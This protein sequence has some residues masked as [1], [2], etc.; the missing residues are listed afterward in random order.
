MIR[1]AALL[2]CLPV[3]AGAQDYPARPVRVLSTF[4]AGS[5]ADALMR[6][7]GAKMG[8]TM[9]QPVVVEVQAGA[10]GILGGQSVARAA[11]DGYTLLYTTATTVMISPRLQKVEPY[12]LR[13]FT[14]IVVVSM[15]VTSMFVNASF[16]ASNMKEFI[17]YVKANPGKVAYG[18]N[19]I[20]GIYHLEMALLSAKYGLEMVHV[21]YKGGTDALQAVAAGTLPV[22]FVPVS[23]ALAQARAGKVKIIG[24]LEPRRNKDLPDVPALGEQLPDYEKVASGV[25]IYG[26]ARIPPAIAKRIHAELHKAASLPEVQQRMKDIAFPYDGTALDEMTAMRIKDVDVVSRAIKA[27][28]L[29]AQ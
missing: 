8:E 2:L 5:P 29:K 22:G 17:E 6:L 24:V 26:P 12:S 18:T 7:L 15:A 1:L 9:G 19:G 20:G 13:D 23:S 14:P 3:V 28:G 25:D 4:T 27:A 16:P 10:G 11:P 21:P